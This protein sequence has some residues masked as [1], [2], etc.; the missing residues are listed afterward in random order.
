MK[1][2]REKTILCKGLLYFFIPIIIFGTFSV[3]YPGV[4]AIF[5]VQESAICIC[6]FFEI[7]INGNGNWVL[8]LDHNSFE[9]MTLANSISFYVVNWLALIILIWLVFRIRHTGDDTNLKRECMTIVMI[10]V[11]CSILQ[12]IIFIFNYVITCHG[13]EGKLTT[14]ELSLRYEIS[15]SITYWLIMARDLACLLSMLVF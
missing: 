13:D 9:T 12:Y 15:Y 11:L 1:D 5:P 10:W 6:S 7:Q 8:H 2:L 14:D 3:F 4:Y